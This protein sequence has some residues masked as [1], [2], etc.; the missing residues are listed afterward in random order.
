[1]TGQLAEFGGKVSLQKTPFGSSK[2]AWSLLDC[3]LVR[4]RGI[5]DVWLLTTALTITG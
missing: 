1:M 4:K 3:T 5:Q 2:D